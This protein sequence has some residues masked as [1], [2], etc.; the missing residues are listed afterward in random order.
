MDLKIIWKWVKVTGLIALPV[1]LLILPATW[2]DSGP[3]YCISRVAFDLECYACGMTRAMM[4]LIHF[5][6]SGAAEYNKLVFVVAPVLGVLWLQLLL[7]QFGKSF[8]K[9]V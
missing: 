2:F 1:T 5:D 7:K 6:F 8:L 3:S 9:W 4:H